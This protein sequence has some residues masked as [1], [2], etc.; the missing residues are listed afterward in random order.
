MCAA[1]AGPG[2][3]FITVTFSPDSAAL[4]TG[5]CLWDI[6]TARSHCLARGLAFAAFRRDGRALAFGSGRNGSITV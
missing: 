6:A 4:A 1:G 5:H 3:E 2:N